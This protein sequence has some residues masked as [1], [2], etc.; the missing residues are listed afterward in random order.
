MKK[1]KASLQDLWDIIKWSYRDIR[2]VLQG[3]E[4]ENGQKAY[5]KHIMTLN[6]PN[7]RREIDI[8]TPRAYRTKKVDYKK[9]YN[10]THYK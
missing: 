5:F 2:G 7:I 8:K 6:V 10:K 1:S 3:E 4:R 9:I